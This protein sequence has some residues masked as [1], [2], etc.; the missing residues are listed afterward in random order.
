MT[1]TSTDRRM[2]LVGNTAIKVPVDCAT[3]ANITLSGEQTIDGVLTSNS[4]VL[5]MNQTNSVD[6]GIYDSDSGAW[7]RSIDCNGTY[8]LV[9][10]TLVE[11]VG[12]SS[13]GGT[14]WV[15][16]GTA[17]LVIGSSAISW[18]AAPLAAGSLAAQLADSSTIGNGD[19]LVATKLNATGA[20]P[21]TQHQ[22][23]ERIVL[24]SKFCAFDGSDERTKIQQAVDHCLGFTPPRSLIVD[25]KVVL[26]SSVNINRTVDTTSDAFVI[27]GINGGGFH[28]NGTVTFFDSTEDLVTGTGPVSENIEFIGL[29]F[30]SSSAFN[31]AYVASSKLLRV[32]FSD[33]FFW[34]IRAHNPTVATFT[35]STATNKLAVSA[36]GSGKLAPNQTLVMAGVS[37]AT[38]IVSQDSGTT[39]GVG[40]YTLSTS[41]G[42]VASTTATT[43]TYLQT[44]HF[45]ANTIRNWPGYFVNASGSYDILFHGNII[46]SG[47]SLMRCV[48]GVRGT[49]GLRVKDN[50]IEGL[51]ASSF[52]LTGCS[53]VVISGNHVEG[54]A[55]N[56]INTFAGTLTNKTLDIS[57]NYVVNNA[58]AYVYHGPSEHVVSKGNSVLNAFHTNATAVTSL[59]SIEDKAGTLSDATFSAYIGNIKTN[60]VVG[61]TPTSVAFSTAISLNATAGNVFVVNVNSTSAF[62]ITAGG[63]A[64]VGQPMTM[65]LKNT[66]TGTMGAVTFDS[67]AFRLA[68]FVAPGSGFRSSIQSYYDGLYFVQSA[69]AV[70]TANT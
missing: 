65:T 26:G 6:N 3:T 44:W 55:A 57:D 66:S 49:T 45:Q 37:S 1:S 19:A 36:V 47:T 7:T 62:S 46:E 60:G 10:G 64:T 31:E 68:A 12:G 54:N 56:D 32:R 23:N 28:A 5:V 52:E 18:N 51:S 34:L 38:Y 58:G 67:A 21:L 63:A 50:L 22:L 43:R 24:A 69:A 59:T 27:Q 53:G 33:C 42:V 15:A 8:D 2:G 16:S 35:A 29:R 13:K 40:V 9:V 41:P 70:I 25:G 48:D 39:G 61:Q 14:F 17:P 20:I 11:V 4:R 30:S